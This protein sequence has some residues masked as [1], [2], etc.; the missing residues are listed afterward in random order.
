MCIY[1]YTHTHTHTHSH[2]HIHTYTHIALHAS[3]WA[4]LKH[5]TEWKKYAAQKYMQCNSIHIK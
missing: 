5:N 4:N 1:I 3:K 2:T